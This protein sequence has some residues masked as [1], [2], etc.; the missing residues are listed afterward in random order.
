[1]I[2]PDPA[3]RSDKIRNYVSYISIPEGNKR[4]MDFIA[5]AIQR[6]R[7]HA[8]QYQDLLVFSYP[9]GLKG[10]VEQNSHYS[11]SCKMK[12]LVDKRK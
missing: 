11:V 6:G 8:E 7:N 5:D 9:E 1:M 3:S 10:P 2:Q 12:Q 4:L